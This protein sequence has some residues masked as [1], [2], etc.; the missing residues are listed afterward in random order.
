MA[1]SASTTASM[2]AIRSV[3]RSRQMP[4]GWP[5]PTPAAWQPFAEGCGASGQIR[6]GQAVIA[7]D[8]GDAIGKPGDDSVEGFAQPGRRRRH[9]GHGCREL[10][11]RQQAD[12]RK[13]RLRRIGS[14]RRQDVGQVF[15]NSRCRLFRDALAVNRHLEG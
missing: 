7:I 10:A 2:P 3:E 8:Q 15:E 9:V 11:R 12:G 6:I 5:G 14:H 4:T 1:P 13:H